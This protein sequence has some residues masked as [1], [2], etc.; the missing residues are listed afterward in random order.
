MQHHK[1]DHPYPQAEPVL[2]LEAIFDEPD[3]IPT[4][5][6]KNKMHIIIGGGELR[7]IFPTT[8]MQKS[9]PLSQLTTLVRLK[10]Y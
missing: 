5:L 2:P 6:E 10:N 8:I 1:P 3:Q 9:F 7:E 4:P